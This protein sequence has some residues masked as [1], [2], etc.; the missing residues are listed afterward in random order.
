MAVY[1]VTSDRIEATLRELGPGPWPYDDLRASGWSSRQLE[2]AARAG[3]LVRVRRGVYDAAPPTATSGDTHR[4]V[5]LGQVSAT[6][7][8]LSS[9]AVASHDSAALV[10]DLWVPGPPASVVHV[11]IPGQP[12]RRA[13]GLYVHASR[14]PAEFVAEI[15]G[16]RVTTIARTA[17]DLA[18]GRSLPDALVAIDGAY[19]RLV[20]AQRPRAKY[21]LRERAVP[22]SLHARIRDELESAFAVTWSWPGTRVV[23]AALDLVEPASESAF[24]SWSRGWIVA[25]GLPHPV[26][27]AEVVGDSGAAYVGDLVWR[28][29]RLIGEAD[30]LGKY[31]ATAL[32]MRAA[33]RAERARQADLEAAGWRFVRWTTGEPG[34]RIVARVARALD[35]PRVTPRIDPFDARTGRFAV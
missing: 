22:L 13:T 6:V 2:A 10:E 25:R 27:N 17:V 34:A 18:R 19:R 31:G 5:S 30:G 33:M 26:V 35:I 11:T 32:E 4:A 23:R 29:R 20:E 28:S 3:A 12:E 21:E 7:A 9:R 8:R 16:I 24:E 15:Q 14:L 1:R